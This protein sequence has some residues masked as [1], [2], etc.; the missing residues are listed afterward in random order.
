MGA[1]AAEEDN[2][3]GPDRIHR[4][5]HV[6]GEDEIQF[7][8]TRLG[9]SRLGGHR[10]DEIDDHVNAF[11][12]RG[13]GRRIE[14]IAQPPFHP[15]TVGR[16]RRVARRTSGERDHVV[17]IRQRSP[18][19]AADEPAGA[20]DGDPSSSV[21]VVGQGRSE[22]FQRHTPARRESLLSWINFFI[23]A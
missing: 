10:V 19:G 18:Q 1:E 17:L 23:S 11:D 4:P 5:P 12:R 21:R 6:V 7:V 22:S 8:E 3:R 13:D 2:V 20:R 15:V 9:Q 14:Q 16:D